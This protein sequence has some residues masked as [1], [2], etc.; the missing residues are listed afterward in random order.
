MTKQNK[1]TAGSGNSTAAQKKISSKSIIAEPIDI[2]NMSDAEIVKAAIDRLQKEDIAVKWDRYGQ[3]M[4]SDVL[5]ALC[6]FCEQNVEFAQAV[7]QTDK[8]LEGCLKEVAKNVVQGISDLE[9]Y[10]RA[11]QFYFAGATVSF[12]MIIDVGDGVLNEAVASAQQEQHIE[13]GL[14]SLLESSLDELMDW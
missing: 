1:N 11:V 7:C 13:V 3:V 14:N 5:N 10:K 8:T 6:C 2:V 9:A 4:H 12:K